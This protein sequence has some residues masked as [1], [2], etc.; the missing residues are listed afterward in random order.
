MK[1]AHSLLLLLTALV[2]FPTEAHEYD[3]SKL[4]G[5]NLVDKYVTEFNSF[6][7]EKYSQEYPNTAASEFMCANIPLFECPDKELEKTYYFRWWTFRKHIRKTPEG[8]VITEFLPN[9]PWAGTYNT[10]CCPASHHFN[11]GRW[12]HNGTFLTDYARFWV[13]SKANPRGYSFPAADAIWSFYLVHHDKTLIHDVYDGLKENY[14]AWEESHRDSTG[15]FWQIDG[16]DG[17]EESVSGALNEDHSGYRPTINSYMYADAMAL[18]K[19]ARLL[20]KKKEARLYKKKATEIK[21]L[22]NKWLWDKRDQFYKSIP[23]HTDMS[24]A[25]CREEFGYVPWMYNIP[26]K[27]KLIAW[28]QLFDEKGFKAPY[29]PTS[30][31]QRS[32]GFR[33][34]YE[35][36]E[37]QWNGPSWPFATSQTLKGMANCLHRFGEKV[38]TKQRYMEVLTTY[39]NSHRLDGHCFIDE[40]LNPYTGD[41]IARTLLMQRGNEIPDRGKDYNHSSF[42]D[43]IISGLVGIEADEKGHVTVRPLVPDGLWDYYCLRD[44]H[45]CGK[46]VTVVYDKDGKH[47]GIGKG[48]HIIVI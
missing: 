10:I 38:L 34:V 20:G 11:E 25:P 30:V 4:P 13:S 9:V 3:L 37:C 22:M 43:L 23:R 48:L 33:I 12:L 18:S 32:P 36:H 42:V 28:E 5:K 17:M 19:M 35:G 7:D 16:Y 41:W 29:G 47:Y 31:E 40:D 6:D 27:D 45:I 44:V 14:K 46:N 2:F 24:V 21:K 39:S 26:K 15:L 8:Y 1:T